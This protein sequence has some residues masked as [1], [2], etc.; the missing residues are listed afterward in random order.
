MLRWISCFLNNFAKLRFGDRVKRMTNAILERAE[1]L[2]KNVPEDTKREVLN[3]ITEAMR[4]P[5]SQTSESPAE[6]PDDFRNIFGI[7][8]KDNANEMQTI[9]EHA[10]ERIDS[11]DWQDRF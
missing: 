11:S 5:D 1:A 10:F 9:I 8:P 4:M 2:L 3:L 7:L 6:N